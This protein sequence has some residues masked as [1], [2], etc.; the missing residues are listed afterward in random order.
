[1]FLQAGVEYFNPD[2]VA[3]L[4]LARSPGLSQAEANSAAWNQGRRLLER[5]IDERKTFA[6]ETTLGGNTITAL[7]ERALASGMAVRVWYV[8]LNGPEL[9]L[10]RVRARVARGGHDIPAAQIRA[11]YDSSRLNLIRLLPKL[12][13]LRV[14]DNSAEADPH[15]GVAPE[16]EL[17]LHM[18][19]GRI[20]GSCA[21]PR[22]PEWAKPIL[23][24]AM[25]SAGV[26]SASST[27]SGRMWS[28]QEECGHRGRRASQR[29]HRGLL[30]GGERMKTMTVFEA[31]NNFS[32][33]L[34]AAERDVVVVTR[35]GRPVAAIQAIGDDDLED[36]LLERSP[37]FWDMIRRA[38]QG[39]PVPLAAARRSLGT[40]R[41]AR[42]AR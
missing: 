39:G 36:L 5:A 37:R 20:V 12:T 14:Y 2:Q 6:F 41:G 11:R 17:V 4:I 29:R 27:T 34:R 28:P 1:M 19:R 10:A 3:R 22:A 26:S 21:L 42:R 33:T 18:S 32:Q 15:A 16:P 30:W 8:A 25:K 13:E 9:H 38:R 23:A 31:R 7:L 40:R 24:A 35:N